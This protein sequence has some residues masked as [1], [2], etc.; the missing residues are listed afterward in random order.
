MTLYP[1]DDSGID[2]LLRNADVAMYRAK[3][4]GGNTYAFY[5]VD[6]TIKARERLALE[7]DL[8]HAVEQEQFVLHYQPIVDLCTGE[9][10]ALEALVRWQRPQRGLTE[11]GEFIPVA[12]ESGLIV[13]LGEWV[14]RAACEQFHA[15]RDAWPGLRLA[16]NVSA[17]QFQQP[18][19]PEMIVAILGR[20][21][22]DPGLLDIEIT[23]SVLMQNMETARGD[24][25]AERL[26][27]TFFGG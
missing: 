20:A 2:G 23:E 12:E 6:M 25:Q 22:F 3:A 13:Q 16:V 5:S 19:L 8:R 10:G 17:R 15:Y 26:R 27:C 18:D 21:R 11:P 7:N 14:L 1:A 24:A 4:A 9:V